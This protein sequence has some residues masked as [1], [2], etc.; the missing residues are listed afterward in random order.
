MLSM[1][2][3]YKIAKRREYLYKKIIC[4]I[5]YGTNETLKKER[6]KVSFR[7]IIT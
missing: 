3:F 7:K 5:V 6:F 2:N 4:L 1:Q